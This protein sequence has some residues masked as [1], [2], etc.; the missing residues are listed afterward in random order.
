MKVKG[1]PDV[2]WKIN[3]V[4]NATEILMEPERVREA[5]VGF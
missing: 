3:E 2:T 4:K 1:R 5:D